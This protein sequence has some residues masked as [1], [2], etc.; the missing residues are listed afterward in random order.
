MI[1]PISLI[2][3]LHY[4]IGQQYEVEQVNLAPTSMRGVVTLFR[5]IK[6]HEVKFFDT[7]LIIYIQTKPVKVFSD[8][9]IVRNGRELYVDTINN[10][11]YHDTIIKYKAN[12]HSSIRR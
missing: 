7:Y 11:M 9:W 10:T 6:T 8:G 3:L 4:L 12:E 1:K 2:K 5:K